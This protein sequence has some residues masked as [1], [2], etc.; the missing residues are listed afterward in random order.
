M[1]LFNPKLDCKI[2]KI[3]QDKNG[4]FVFAKLTTDDSHFI[5]VNIYSPNDINQQVSVG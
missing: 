3:V 1:I 5:L 4:R 2:A